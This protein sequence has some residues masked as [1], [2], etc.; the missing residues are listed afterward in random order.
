MHKFTAY[1]GDLR[2]TLRKTGNSEPSITVETDEGDGIDFLIKGHKI[3]K[4][5]YEEWINQL[6]IVIEKLKKLK[7]DLQKMNLP[8]AINLD[9]SPRKKNDLFDYGLNEYDAECEYH[10]WLWEL[11]NVRLR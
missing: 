7:E 1:H 11:K 10:T 5:N 4:E 2:L 8:P 9:G 6:Q 3:G